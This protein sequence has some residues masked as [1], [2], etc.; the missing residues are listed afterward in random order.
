MPDVTDWIDSEAPIR[1][2]LVAEMQRIW[3]RTLVR[4]WRVLLAAALLTAAI[5]YKVGSKKPQLEADIVLALSE[6]QLAARE[7]GLPAL[8]L[9]DYVNTVLLPDAKLQ[10]LIEQRDLFRLRK[11]LG[12]EFALDELRSQFDIQVWKNTF[13]TDT[14]EDEDGHS[15][16]IGISVTDSDPDHAYELAQ[17]LAAII[18]ET[19]GEQRAAIAKQLVDYANATRER[20]T[21]RVE[22]IE[23]DIAVAQRDLE[24]ARA[25]SNGERVAIGQ[26]QIAQLTED[27]KVATGTLA[28]VDDSRDSVADRIAA[29]G[30]DVSVSIVE[31]H[32][33]AVSDH[34]GFVFAMVLVVVG[35]GALL[36][37]ALVLGAFDARVHDTDD[38]ERLGLDVLGHLPGFPGDQV[39][40]LA[41]RGAARR[42]VPSFSRWR[43]HR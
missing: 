32:K 35:F 28:K 11:K 31:E 43:S 7:S 26:L 29:A 25:A 15:A 23:H 36:G 21:K 6:G 4:P 30:L 41:Q 3:R 37:S 27:A 22:Q 42:R 8:Q 34:G 18:T 40:S 14:L 12:M 1:S 20:A 17:D 16:R 9:R 38:I 10:H 19:V 5:G 24:D 33:P 13:S 39:G 2:G